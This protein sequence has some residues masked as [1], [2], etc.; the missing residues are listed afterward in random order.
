MK[1]LVICITICVLLAAGCA[2][3]PAPAPKA[4]PTAC[5]AD[6]RTRADCHSTHRCPGGDR[7]TG[8]GGR[9]DRS[10]PVG[11]RVRGRHEPS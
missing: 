2:A 10:N 7:D 5:P 11:G 8:E 6:R 3:P 1:Q 9:S 4:A